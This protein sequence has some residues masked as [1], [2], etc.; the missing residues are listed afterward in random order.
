MTMKS[1]SYKRDSM[2]S[3]IISGGNF[4]NMLIQD[5]IYYI[6]QIFCIRLH[7]KSC[8]IMAIVADVSSVAH[9]PLVEKYKIL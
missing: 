1:S 7:I 3:I 4:K 5:L 8:F 6:V 2:F 9:G